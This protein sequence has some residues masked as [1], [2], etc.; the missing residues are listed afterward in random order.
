MEQSA[1]AAQFLA[2]L[3]PESLKVGDGSDGLPVWVGVDAE[4]QRV[5]RVYANGLAIGFGDGDLISMIGV[6]PNA[7]RTSEVNTS[8]KYIIHAFGIGVDR[9]MHFLELKESCPA[10]EIPIP[11]LPSLEELLPLWPRDKISVGA[12]HPQTLRSGAAVVP[13]E[14][15]QLIP[16]QRQLWVLGRATLPCQ[17]KQSAA[18]GLS[19][20]FWLAWKILLWGIRQSIRERSSVGQKH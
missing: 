10:G 16:H 18:I 14:I 8:G 11:D 5:Y 12:Q 6:G 17:E 3:D 15:D 4:S 9:K 7:G 1:K 20:S 19:G 13:H 2:S